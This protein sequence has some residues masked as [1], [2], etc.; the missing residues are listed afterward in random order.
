MSKK[1]VEGKK[2]CLSEKPIP[3]FRLYSDTVDDDKLRLLAFEDRWHFIA[4]LCCKAK[5]IIDSADSLL[6]RR[7]SVRLGLSSRELEEVARRLAEVG[8]INAETLQPVA[9]DQRQ[10]YSDTD[11]TAADRKRTQREREKKEQC[12]VTRDVTQMSRVQ[13]KSIEEEIEV[14]GEKTSPYQ[15]KNIGVYTGEVYTRDGNPF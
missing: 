6:Y 12:H 13:S 5:G 4:L 7:I 2:L 1:P 11:P 14:E 15:R 9:W 3:W 8:L 10:F